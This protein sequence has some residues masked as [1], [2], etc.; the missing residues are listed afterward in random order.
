MVQ[1]IGNGHTG[2]GIVGVDGGIHGAVGRGV[3]GDQGGVAL[4][5]HAVLH[6]LALDS[7]NVVDGVMGVLGGSDIVIA[8]IQDVGL[9]GGVV[10]G[11]E[12]FLVKGHRDRFGSAGRQFRGL[13]IAHQ[14][15]G[16]LFDVVGLVVIGVGALGKDFHHVLAGAGT[17]VL[18]VHR[19]GAGGAIPGSL[20]VGPLKVGV[21]QAVAEG[22]HYRISIAVVTG[23][24][25]A[26]DGILVPGLIVAVADVDTLDSPT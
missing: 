20:V 22:I 18:H 23:I 15:N 9:G 2:G 14:F 26:Q 8:R 21:G 6:S 24:A 3:G 1:L 12:L 4:G 13:G 19:D 25:L 11:L 17:G 10:V 5:G 7:Q 16:S